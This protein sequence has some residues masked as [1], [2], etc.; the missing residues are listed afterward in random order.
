M[1]TLDGY[2][3]RKYAERISEYA[4]NLTE[5]YLD[6]GSDPGEVMVLSR[7]GEGANFVSRVKEELEAREIPYDGKKDHDRYRP[8]A[9]VDPKEDGVSVFT[10]HQAKGREA[11]HVIL[12]NVATGNDGFSPD[13]R[14]D[15]LLNLVRDV[16]ANEEAEERR[17][18]YVALT[19]SENT[20][21]LL[22]RADE[23]SSFLDEISEFVVRE[24]TIADPG[25][26]GDR[27]FIRATVERLWENTHES[28]R[29][30]GL[31]EDD[32]GRIKFV[33]WESANLPMVREGASYEFDGVEVTE[34]D[35]KCE[36]HLTEETTVRP[37]N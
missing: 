24:R 13:A 33:S 32:S 20:L 11:A 15:E 12:L 31:L 23:E 14:N 7:Y 25:C 26:V 19:R 37:D 10:A 18:F 29:Q 5:Q 35:G 8:G 9:E 17:L 2:N 27:V 28:Q 22:T 1:H 34:Y 16:P 30:A 3:D 4:A 21:D 6:D 36:I